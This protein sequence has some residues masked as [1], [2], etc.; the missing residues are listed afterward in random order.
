M[1]AYA[2]HPLCERVWCRRRPAQAPVSRISAATTLRPSPSR[3]V[4]GSACGCGIHRL[5][6]QPSRHQRLQP[7]GL[8]KPV[9]VA[10]SE[11]DQF[12]LKRG[13]VFEVSRCQLFKARAVPRL[14]QSA[15]AHD[16]ALVCFSPSTPIQPGPY[17]WMVWAS[18]RSGWNFMV[19]LQCEVRHVPWLAGHLGVG[20]SEL[21]SNYR[22]R[23]GTPCL[24][25]PL[26]PSFPPA[27]KTVPQACQCLLRHPGSHHGRGQADGGRRSQDHQA[28]YWQSGGLWF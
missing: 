20:G 25:W 24:G 10:T 13:Q 1:P 28:Q 11:D 21:W 12:G 9:A 16:Q 4:V 19:C 7:C 22:F 26:S 18:E 8:G 23:Q 15:R 2:C 17:P 27:M 3:D 14:Q 5:Q 6:A